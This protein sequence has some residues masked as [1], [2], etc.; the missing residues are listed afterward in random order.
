MGN[1]IQDCSIECNSQAFD[2]SRTKDS[3]SKELMDQARPI[4]LG[5]DA[6]PMIS[7]AELI[8]IWVIERIEKALIVIIRSS[9]RTIELN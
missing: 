8:S 6:L 7:L 3:Q 2:V 9:S 5:M 4:F 1:S